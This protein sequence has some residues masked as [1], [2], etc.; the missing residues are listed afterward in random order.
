MIF[1]SPTFLDSFRYYI[2]AEPEYATQARQD[3]LDRLNG[4]SVTNERM[5]AGIDFENALCNYCD[6]LLKFGEETPYSRCIEEMS[7]HVKG[8]SRQVEVMCQLTDSVVIR[9]YIDFLLGNTIIDVKTTS[10]YDCP[11]YLKNN[12]HRAYMGALHEKGITRFQ[13]LVTDFKDVFIEE[14]F[15]HES[16]LEELRGRVNELF[17]YL[18]DDVEMRQAFERKAGRSFRRA[19]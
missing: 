5:Q 11:K 16:M 8:A 6:G 1:I 19:A 12:Q 14:Y 7:G 4:V 9:G 2:D 10:K 18:E 15:W 3:L 13:Y 17:S